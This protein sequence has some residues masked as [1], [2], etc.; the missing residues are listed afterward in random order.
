LTP[1]LYVD[2]SW[3]EACLTSDQ[4][5][6]AW[7]LR[8]LLGAEAA[9]KAVPRLNKDGRIQQVKVLRGPLYLSKKVSRHIDDYLSE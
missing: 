4:D 5:I 9:K 7:L 3:G 2:S 8:A 1:G 6:E